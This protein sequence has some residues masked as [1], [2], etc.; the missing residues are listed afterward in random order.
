M[1]KIEPCGCAS[2]SATSRPK[3]SLAGGT[4]GDGRGPAGGFR[5]GETEDYLYKRNQASPPPPGQGPDGGLELENIIEMEA[6]CAERCSRGR[7]RHGRQRALSQLD[8]AP[9]Q[10]AVT[11]QPATCAWWWRRRP[12]WASRTTSRCQMLPMS[13]LHGRQR[14][15]VPLTVEDLQRTAAAAATDARVPF[16]EICEGGKCRLEADLG[17]ME[18]GDSGR[19]SPALPCPMM[20]PKMC[21]SST[22]DTEGDVNPG[23]NRTPICRP[24]C[25]SAP[26]PSR[27]GRRDGGLDRLSDLHGGGR[28]RRTAARSRSR[29]FGE[30]GST[31]RIFS[32]ERRDRSYGRR[33]RLLAG[34]AGAARR[35]ASARGRVSEDSRHRR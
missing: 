22:H 13:H 6:A 27:A 34:S 20:S 33:R 9:A 7:L 1:G 14:A 8:D 30:P 12:T 15:H 11:S 29:G 10:S 16:E 24:G 26:P 28:R 2:P 32:R 31:L 19:S 35:L 5:L 25:P 23:N 17:F 18:P 4:V 3:R 21:T